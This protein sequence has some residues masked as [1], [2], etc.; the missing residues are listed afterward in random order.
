MNKH[1]ITFGAFGRL[2]FKK[3]GV[4]VLNI[5]LFFTLTWGNDPIGSI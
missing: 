3:L 2:G 5:S 4:V 1:D